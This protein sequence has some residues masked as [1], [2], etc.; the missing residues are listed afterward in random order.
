[1]NSHTERP[2]F[3]FTCCPPEGAIL[4]LPNGA[5][6]IDLRKR[7]PMRDYIT[8][9]IA[10]WYRSMDD[11]EDLVVVTGADKCSSWGT[12]CYSNVS[13]AAEMSLSFVP[14]GHHTDD[15]PCDYTWGNYNP[16][17]TR[18]GRNTME[19]SLQNRNQCTF[20]RGYKTKL[21]K[22]K[23]FPSVVSVCDVETDTPVGDAIMKGR[24]GSSRPSKTGLLG[25]NRGEASKNVQSD[26]L[27]NTIVVDDFPGSNEVGLFSETKVVAQ[28]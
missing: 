1:M 2:S 17:R 10:R 23:V 24:W 28:F 19:G 22:R 13:R 12:A 4:T 27:G 6:R 15:S 21:R 8:R 11:D 14:T 9:N 25:N 26:S 16:I 20:I 18:G 7:L 5:S 3:Q